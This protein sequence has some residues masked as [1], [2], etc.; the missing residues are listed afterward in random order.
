MVGFA[1]AGR[2]IVVNI[3]NRR[4]RLPSHAPPSVRALSVRRVAAR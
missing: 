1:E 2:Q 3:V 4:R